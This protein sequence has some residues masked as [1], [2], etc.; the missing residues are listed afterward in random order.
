MLI[1]IA[2]ANRVF[3]GK[4]VL[5]TYPTT[6]E[7]L[8]ETFSDTDNCLTVLQ[9]LCS[10]DKYNTEFYIK[11]LSGGVREL[12]IGKTGKLFTY[13]FQYG[14]GKG[15]YELT[16]EKVSSANIITRLNVYG[17]S[18][19]I[20]TS[21]Y[22]ASK[23]CLPTKSKSQS[24]IEDATAI[25]TYGIWENTKNFDDIFPERVGTVSALGANELKFIDSSLDFD[26]NAKD[27]SGNTLYLIAGTSAKIRFNTGNLAGYEFEL[28]SYDHSTKQFTL[29]SITDEN[30]YVFPS[31]TSS[32]FKISVGDK[33]IITDIYLPQSYINSAE[34]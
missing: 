22:R 25:A 10:E 16:R 27:V 1:L 30:G 17:G 3:P 21:K 18:K 5:G 28:S 32:A 13:T 15:I 6:T 8:T 34:A 11:I 23:L 26:L 33:Y 4:W 9:N 29:I 7:T 24:F 19:N 14:K 20:I 31:P 2:N 12:N